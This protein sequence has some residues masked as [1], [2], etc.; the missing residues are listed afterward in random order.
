M[1]TEVDEEIPVNT[2]ER[3][4]GGETISEVPTEVITT[5]INIHLRTPALIFLQ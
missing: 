5:P 1:V 2:V 3:G 4:E